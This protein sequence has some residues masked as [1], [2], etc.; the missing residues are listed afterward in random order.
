MKLIDIKM[1]FTPDILEDNS[2]YFWSII[3]YLFSFVFFVLIFFAF[4]LSYVLI[5]LSYIF[6]IGSIVIAIVSIKRDALFGKTGSIVI[7]IALSTLVGYPILD[8]FELDYTSALSFGLISLPILS[9]PVPYFLV[10][11]ILLSFKKMRTDQLQL[12]RRDSKMISIL[13]F[14]LLIS[15]ILIV[16]GFLYVFTETGTYREAF[17]P[18]LPESSDFGCGAIWKS[19]DFGW[20]RPD[21]GKG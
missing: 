7:I 21:N 10:G 14:E 18:P 15:I 4:N 6:S 20:D 5:A 8:R 17:G 19:P 9:L 16:L 1:K 13:K 11:I 3:S 12:T 2:Y